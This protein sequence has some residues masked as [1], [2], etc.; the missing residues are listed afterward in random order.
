MPRYRE[1]PVELYA[2]CPDA[3]CP[4]N[5]PTKVVGI[6]QIVTHTYNDAAGLDVNSRTVE[7]PMGPYEERSFEYLRV[8]NPDDALCPAC[9]SRTR[10][11]SMT[12]RPKYESRHGFDQGALL[13]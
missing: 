1:E 5:T 4:G 13:K 12:D 9:E 11:L 3:M 6:K 8:A 7:N 10:E 2:Y